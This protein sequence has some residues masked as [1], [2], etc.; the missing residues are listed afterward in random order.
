MIMKSCVFAQEFVQKEAN[1]T[2]SST[3]DF[4]QR[5]LVVSGK[6]ASTSNN[7]SLAEK[8]L[9]ALTEARK[10][11]ITQAVIAISNIEIENT[12]VLKA[13]EMSGTLLTMRIQN[14]LRGIKKFDEHTEIMSDGSVLATVNML[15]EFDGNNGL[16]ALLFNTLYPLVESE[17]KIDI[18]YNE[19]N[20]TGFVFDVSRFPVRP[21][22]T[23][24]VYL[25]SGELVYGPDIVSREYAIKQGIVGYTK[26]LKNVADRVGD[27]PLMI[28]VIKLVQGDNSSIIISNNDAA[29][30]R[31]KDVLRACRVAFLVK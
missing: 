28:N 30:L 23:P 17:S 2:G 16:N 18:K 24:R 26:D 10:N 7:R 1:S 13:A 8:K 29:K 25:E 12:T 22:M 21:S 9:W 20:I 3:V 31:Q 14:Y 6:G 27:N 5:S 4:I 15:I 19:N 11:C